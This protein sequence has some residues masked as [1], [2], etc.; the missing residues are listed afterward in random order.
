MSL[1]LFLTLFSRVSN[2]TRNFSFQKSW[3]ESSRSITQVRKVFLYQ[4]KSL[5]FLHLMFGRSSTFLSFKWDESPIKYREI[6]S[7][8]VDTTSWIGLLD[9]LG[10]VFGLYMFEWIAES[11]IFRYQWDGNP[12]IVLI[13]QKILQLK[14]QLW[15][16]FSEF[17]IWVL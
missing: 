4:W 16:F 1:I 6:V 13:G 5:S 3:F 10:L 7:I 14:V 2:A 17:L 12:I 8:R 11:L 15:F 9:G